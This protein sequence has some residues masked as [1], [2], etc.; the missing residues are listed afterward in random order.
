MSKNDERILM[1][2]KSIEEQESQLKE[3]SKYEYRTNKVLTLDTAIHN[4]NVISLNQI[5]SLLLELNGVRFNAMD[6]KVR[7]PEVDILSDTLFSGYSIDDWISDL[8]HQLEVV[9]SKAKVSKL[10]A[11]KK[12]LDNMLSEDKKTELLLDELSKNLG[13]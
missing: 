10:K 3:V 12:Q 8:V 13:I 7:F 1:L 4:L 9:E 6:L 2:K 11:A 5:H